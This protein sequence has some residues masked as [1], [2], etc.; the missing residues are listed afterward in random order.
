LYTYCGIPALLFVVLALVSQEPVHGGDR[1]TDGVR[2]AVDAGRLH[3]GWEDLFVLLPDAVK[4]SL[5]A[6]FALCAFSLGMAVLAG[7]G[8]Q[9]FIHS[10]PRWVQAAIVAVV[11]A[12]LIAVSSARPMNTVDERAIRASPTTTLTAGRRSRRRYG[13]W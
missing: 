10:R 6:E 4:G 2:G 11:A 1:L 9:Q 3:A 5:Y 7:L 12:D 8:A 13:G